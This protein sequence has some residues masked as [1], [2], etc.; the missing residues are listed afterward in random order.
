VERDDRAVVPYTI[1]GVIWY[2]GEANDGTEEHAY[3][4]RHLFGFP[5]LLGIVWPFGGPGVLA[6]LGCTRF[7]WRK[8]LGP[9]R[10]PVLFVQ[11][12]NYQTNGSGP[13]LAA[14]R[15]T[16]TA[17]RQHWNGQSH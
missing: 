15:S 14:N 11:L 7:G 17:P 1:R 5:F 8:Q 2:Q 16:E 12:A 6:F 4:Y 9:G 3:H 10:S 13:G